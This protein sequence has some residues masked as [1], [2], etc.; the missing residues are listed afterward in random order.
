MSTTSQ[1]VE[2]RRREARLRRWLGDLHVDVRYAVR[3]SGRA[4]TFTLVTMATL[5]LAIGVNT[6]IFSVVNSLLLRPLPVSDPERLAL[7]SSASRGHQG[8]FQATWPHPVWQQI[9]EISSFDAALAWSDFDVGSAR[10]RFDLG[11]GGEA[12]LVDGLFVSSGFFDA[13]G[14]RA[15]LGRTFTERDA[16]AS[17][18]LVGVISYGLWQRRFGGAADVVGRSMLVERTPVTVIGV[19]PPEFFGV[20]VGRS[21]DVIVPIVSAPALLRNPDVLSQSSVSVMVRLRPEQ[22]FESATA[23]LRGMQARLY[24]TAMPATCAPCRERFVDDPFVLIEAG[25]GISELRG[26]YRQPLVTVLVIAS[27]VLLA[28]CANI[29]NLMLARGTARRQEMSIRAAVGASRWRIARQMLVESVLLAGAGALAGLVLA[30]WASAA[31]VA[32][33]ATINTSVVLDLEMDWRVM[34]F[35]AGLTAATAIAF[36]TVPALRAASVARDRTAGRGTSWPL[37]GLRSSSGASSGPAP[38]RG[39]VHSGIVVQVA[40]SL[41]LVVAAGLFVRSF[42]RLMARPLGFDGDR[43]LVVQVNAARSLVEPAARLALYAQLVEAV[44]AVPGVA[45]AAASQTTPVSVTA[46]AASIVEDP[47][48]PQRPLQDRIVPTNHVSP[49]WFAAYGSAIRYGRDFEARDV[50]GARPVTIVNEAFVRQYLPGANPIGRLVTFAPGPQ[51]PAPREIVGVVSDSILASPSERTIPTLFEPFAQWGA[52]LPPQISISVRAAAGP[53]AALTGAIAAA[54]LAEDPDLSFSAR[55]L[56]AQVD[57]SLA[58]NRLLAWVSGVF[59]A[60]ALL[61]AG[62]GLYGITAYAVGQR[63]MELGLRMALGANRRGIVELVLLRVA[64]LVLAGVVIGAAASALMSQL[65]ASLLYGVE[66]RD[67]ATFAAATLTLVTVGMLAAAVPAYRAAL[68]DPW[69]VLREQ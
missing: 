3:Q 1:P 40:L 53:P 66:P 61:L 12:Q 34:T 50:A 23:L 49:G 69:T 7:V 20:E 38:S 68:V 63:R 48:D 29:A 41:V 24:D 36:G 37:L 14:V 46:V 26:Q 60:L 9:E 11:D 27:L 25:T 62:V 15:R 65:T 43:V 30:I 17:G 51:R 47:R 4:P 39:A 16:R 31:L 18:D 42:E 19:L 44:A 2:E 45:R 58:R 55:P 52:T 21:V 59:G 56:A 13:L 5:A 64:F 8:Y 57:A 33:L 10:R 6:A 28:A 32:Q 67:P 35:A 22:S 54:L